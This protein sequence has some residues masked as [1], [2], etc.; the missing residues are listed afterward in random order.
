MI[1]VYQLN[2]QKLR[3]ENDRRHFDVTFEADH[4]AVE[5]AWKEGYYDLAATINT[6][7][8]D[9]AYF[10]TNS[11]EGYWPDNEGVVVERHPRELGGW[12]STSI[13]DVLEVNGWFYVVARFGFDALPTEMERET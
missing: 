13:G 10:L 2:W 1:R 4:A 3:A 6:D 12:R 11:I 9:R 7:D 5:A 8:K